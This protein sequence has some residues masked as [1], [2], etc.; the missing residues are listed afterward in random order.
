VQR[1]TL[2]AYIKIFKEYKT[3]NS[4]VIASFTGALPLF[5]EPVKK[6]AEVGILLIPRFFTAF[7]N[8]LKRRGISLTIPHWRTLMFIVATSVVGYAMKFEPETVKPIYRKIIRR[9]YLNFL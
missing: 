6:R 5:I 3:I 1:L 7:L 9:F 2:C 8:F 4:L